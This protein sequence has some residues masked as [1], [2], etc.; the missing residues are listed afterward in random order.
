MLKTRQLK[1]DHI[2]RKN[3]WNF[4]LYSL[5]EPLSKGFQNTPYF[6][7]SHIFS[8]FGCCS[9][10][11]KEMRAKRDGIKIDLR[12]YSTFWGLLQN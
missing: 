12:G 8:K 10:H 5:K 6:K 9:K 1:A 2:V 3:F 4:L 11:I 7:Q